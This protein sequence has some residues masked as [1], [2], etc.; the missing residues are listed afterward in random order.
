[1]L[2]DHRS[3]IRQRCSLPYDG[4]GF[5]PAIDVTGESERRERDIARTDFRRVV[6]PLTDL[7]LGPGLLPIMAVAAERLRSCHCRERDK[8]DCDLLHDTLLFVNRDLGTMTCYRRA[9][10]KGGSHLFVVSLLM[11]CM[12]IVHVVGEH[13]S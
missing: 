12:S 1:M 11:A 2:L 13:T 4:A 3:H 5:I 8:N 10:T 7:L 9:L 6:V